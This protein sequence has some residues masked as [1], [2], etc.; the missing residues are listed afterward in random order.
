[1]QRV[2]AAP[3]EGID[4]A[5]LEVQVWLGC[6]L[7]TDGAGDVTLFDRCALKH[8]VCDAVEVK[9]YDE[10]VFFAVRRVDDFQHYVR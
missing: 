9:V 4:L 2:A 1:M 3:F 8:A 5:E 7:P 6:I 10:Q